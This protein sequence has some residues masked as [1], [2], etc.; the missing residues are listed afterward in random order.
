MLPAVVSRLMCLPRAGTGV[1]A[2]MSAHSLSKQMSLSP[3]W[4]IVPQARV[5][6]G[7]L[8]DLPD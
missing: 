5:N 2:V 4:E 7:T 8:A 3:P 6:P 1:A